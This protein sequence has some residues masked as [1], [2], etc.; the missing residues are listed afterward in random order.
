MSQM[1][2]SSFFAGAVCKMYDDLVDNPKLQKYKTEF[3]LELLK[4][5]HYIL[6]T[7]VS[8]N[9]PIFFVIYYICNVLYHICDKKSFHNPYE[10]SLLYSFSTVFFLI[11]YNTL[12]NNC[13]NVKCWYICAS[14][15]CFICDSMFCKKEY[16]VFK[17]MVR[18]YLLI[19]NILIILVFSNKDSKIPINVSFYII[20]YLFISIM[21]QS[22]SLLINSNNNIIKKDK[23]KQKKKKTFI[24]IFRNF[25]RKSIKA[26]CPKILLK[27]INQLDLV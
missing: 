3:L 24:K 1:M 22:Y 25:F 17:L 12:I 10:H 7:F 16:G 20:G 19:C 11:N 2:I 8:I 4:G 27:L 14:F 23:K 9:Q 13:N 18:V 15:L 21:V 26:M 5:L 6:F